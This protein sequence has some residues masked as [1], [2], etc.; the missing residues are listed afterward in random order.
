MATS[1][2]A[3]LESYRSSLQAELVETT[4][5]WVL[6][7]DDYA[8]KVKK[9]L[10]LPF[11]DYGSR[12]RRLFCC[13]EEI[14]LNSRFAPDLYL[15]VVRI[16]NTGEAAVRMRRFDEAGRLDR[17][18]ARRSLTAGE[19][20]EL[21]RVIGGI[22]ATARSPRHPVRSAQLVL[23]SVELHELLPRL[24]TS[25]CV[26]ERLAAQVRQAQQRNQLLSASGQGIFARVTVICT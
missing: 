4:I 14:R 23:P 6:L 11:L 26:S 5:S 1:V 2:P 9:P 13:Q 19:L 10:S 22:H 8:Y 24:T 18:C 12:Q 15:D 3:W 20:R 16:G 21:A 17:V 25:W 7:T